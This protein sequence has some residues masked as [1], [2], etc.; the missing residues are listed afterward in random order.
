[1]AADRS[2][3]ELP[4]A[5]VTVLL[6]PSLPLPPHAANLMHTCS[7]VEGREGDG[8]EEWGRPE[9]WPAADFE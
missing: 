4:A 1:M 8:E 3:A 2:A 7:T 6:R 5:T 9:M